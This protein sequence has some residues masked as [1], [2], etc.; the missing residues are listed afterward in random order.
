MIQVVGH[1]DRRDARRVDDALDAGR[2]R[3]ASTFS[4]PVTLT[5]SMRGRSA[6][7]WDTIPARLIT[8]DI[9]SITGARLARSVTSP[10]RPRRRA[11][12]N[13][14]SRATLHHAHPAAIRDESRNQDRPMK[15]VAPATRTAD[16]STRAQHY[17]PAAIARTDQPGGYARRRHERRSHGSARPS[18]QSPAFAR[19]T[20]RRRSDWPSRRRARPP[21][22]SAAR[23]TGRHARRWRSGRRRDRSTI[24]L[25]ACSRCCTAPDRRPL[26]RRLALVTRHGVVVGER[27]VG[28][29]SQ[30]DRGHD[31]RHAVRPRVDDE[32][33]RHRDAR[34]AARP[35]PGSR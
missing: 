21:T 20:V 6:S 11:P 1:A 23:G 18:H 14:G 7:R 13:T 3:P 8:D 22:S 12:S 16:S 5:A 19:M 30:V 26:P 15:Q 35:A 17:P 25:E 29:T 34:D 10:R 28:S 4:A 32:G 9:P 33:A 27:A 24:A 31:D 2:A